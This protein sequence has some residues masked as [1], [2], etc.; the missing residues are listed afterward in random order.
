MLYF[1]RG[2]PGRDPSTP[3]SCAPRARRTP[4]RMTIPSRLSKLLQKPH[5]PLKEVLQIIHSVLQQGQP[6]HAH[7]ERKSRYL[8]RVVSVV[9]HK[10]EHIGINHSAAEHLN[11]S[12]LFAGTAR[13]RSALSATA[14]DEARSIQFR[15]RF[16]E[17][18]E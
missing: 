8:L 18:E 10:L 9:L 7:S 2:Q 16:G 6:I 15:A 12:C 17:W 11:P 4:L 13:V 14:A 3:P 5:I 1:R